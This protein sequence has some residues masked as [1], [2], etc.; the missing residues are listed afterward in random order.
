MTGID[1]SEASVDLA[2]GAI[3]QGDLVLEI[4]GERSQY[5]ELMLTRLDSP[6]HYGDIFFTLDIKQVD[7]R[8]HEN[9][10]DNVNPPSI[11][12]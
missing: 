9:F 10:R 1:L 2:N 4:D 7:I 8:K 11:N 6:H 5:R 3:Y 12:F